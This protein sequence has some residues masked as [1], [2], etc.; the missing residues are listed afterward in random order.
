ML[1][2][3]LVFSKVS[4]EE[5]RRVNQLFKQ[6]DRN[7]NGVIEKNELIQAYREANSGEANLD[8]IEYVLDKID[9]DKS[10][11]INLN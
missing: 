2:S 4:P 3:Y 1:E 5:R 10:G 7:S 8:E 11:C 9:K 6:L